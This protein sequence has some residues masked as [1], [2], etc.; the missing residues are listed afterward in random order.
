MINE[1]DEND[2]FLLSYYISEAKT[3]LHYLKL[4]DYNSDD[5]A[6]CMSALEH[7]INELSKIINGD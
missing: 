7:Y 4:Y 1:V 3:E 6:E 2:D 5:Y